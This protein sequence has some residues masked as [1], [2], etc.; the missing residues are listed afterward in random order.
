METFNIESKLRKEIL[1]SEKLK[2]YLLALVSLSVII[3]FFLIRISFTEY[4]AKYSLNIENLYV[5]QIVLFAFIIREIFVI[6]FIKRKLRENK[7]ISDRARYITNFIEVSFPSVVLL[8][9][10]FY[11]ES[12]EILFAPFVYL[13]FIIIILSTLSL[14]FKISISIGFIAAIEYLLVFFLLK[15]QFEDVNEIISYNN[16][17]FHIGKAI[18]FIMGGVISGIVAKQIKKKILI[19]NNALLER[20]KI[21]NMFGQQISSTIV[22]ELIKNDNEIK[23]QRKYVCVMFLDIRGFTPFAEKKEPEEII[24]Y[25]NDVFGFMIEIIN[26]HN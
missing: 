10:G 15:Q 5:I 11:T 2:A 26:K 17:V 8:I 24:K 18:L 14:D 1:L 16:I 3:V 21:I 7:E 4:L 13:Y 12:T 20:N 19:V 22:D 23:S 6:N 9:L 25:Q